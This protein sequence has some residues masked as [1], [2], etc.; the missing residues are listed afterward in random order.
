MINNVPT[1]LNDFTIG[2]T[3]KL[4]YQNLNNYETINYVYIVNNTHKLKGVISLRDLLR[5]PDRTKIDE[6]MIPDPQTVHPYTD[7]EKVAYKAMKSNLKSMPV[8]DK[9]HKFLGIVPSDTILTITYAEAQE[10]LLRFAGVQPQTATSDDIMNL[11]VKTSLLHRLPWLFIGL[12]GGLLGASIITNFK[13]TLEEN[14]ILAAFIPLVVYTASAV[15]MQMQAF[16]IRDIVINPKFNF[17]HY[18]KRQLSVVILLAII[19]SISLWTIA[20]GIYQ[21]FT[22]AAILGIALFATVLSSLITG[23]IIPYLFNKI[24]L[25]PANASGPIGTITQDIISLTIYLTIATWFL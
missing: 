10:N 17:S 1:A 19:I 9:G 14:L 23:L 3:K 12:L 16:Y 15:G 25:D 13:T 22:L 2:E 8:V 18:F 7:Q 20:F 6:A 4:F 21:E 11:P 24:N 5:L